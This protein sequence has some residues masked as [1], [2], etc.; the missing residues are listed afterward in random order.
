MSSTLTYFLLFWACGSGHLWRLIDLVGSI[1]SQPEENDG[2][3]MASG[4]WGIDQTGSDPDGGEGLDRRF[5][6][7]E[8]WGPRGLGR[9]RPLGFLRSICDLDRA[10]ATRASGVGER[11]SAAPR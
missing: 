2:L 5:Q 6:A 8:A 9:W 1:G 3:E 4:L 10:T 7:G 11:P